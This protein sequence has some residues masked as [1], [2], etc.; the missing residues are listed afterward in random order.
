MNM[1]VIVLG[2]GGHAKVLIN[3]LQLCSVEIL[4][5]TDPDPALIGHEILGV[6][7]IGPD[8]NLK[9]YSVEKVHLVNGLGS[10][11]LP[12]ARCKIFEKYKKL[13]FIFA[14]V[15]HPTAIIA[16]A[17]KIGEGAQLMA[18][19]ILQPGVCIGDNVIINTRASIDHDCTIGS[20]SH[21]APG[22]TLSGDV[23]VG[24]VAHVGAGASIVQGVRVGDGS[25]VG[26]GSVV[27]KDIPG[28]VKAYGCPAKVVTQ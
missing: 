13:G 8:A 26:A 19:V 12:K 7:V 14:T 1:P 22:V 24:T 18:G 20:H 2:A 15:V 6:P 28:S 5:I 23:Q 16:A 10:V 17:V 9:H 3:T 27:L 4:G 25:L 21:I 11:C